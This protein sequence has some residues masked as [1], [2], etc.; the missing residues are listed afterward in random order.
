MLF[1]VGSQT[2]DPLS[3]QARA[4]VEENNAVVD[5]RDHRL[6]R[7]TVLEI[8]DRAPATAQLPQRVHERLAEL[9]DGHPLALRYLINMMDED[10]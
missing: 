7:G 10:R 9:S 1:V 4:H 2:L 6:P 3:P 5:L 8:C